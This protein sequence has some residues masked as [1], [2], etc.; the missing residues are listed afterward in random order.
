MKT[1][2]KILFAPFI[3]LVHACSP[4]GSHVEKDVS[5]SFYFNKSK[6]DV[7]YSPMGNWFE[8]EASKMEVDVASF[9]VLNRH[10][11]K[12]K[13]RAYYQSTYIVN[14]DLDL[15]SFHTKQDQYMYNI[16]MDHQ[17]VYLFERNYSSKETVYQIITDA[18]PQTF[19]IIDYD[20]AKDNQH[21]YH[22]YKPVQVDY[23]SF[24]RINNRFHM[25][26]NQA[27]YHTHELFESFD[28]D[29]ESF[30]KIDDVYAYDKNYVYHFVEY[31]KD[32]AENELKLIPNP[33]SRK[34]RILNSTH[35]T[36]GEKIYYQGFEIE[37]VDINTFKVIHEYHSKDRYKVYFEGI[38]IVGADAESFHYDDKIYRYKDK[39]HTYN[40][41]KPVD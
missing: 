8:L 41:G 19:T 10:I 21:Y 31:V 38:E 7:I 37:G 32:R 18:D 6:T 14:P 29:V 20:W 27:Y 25:D 39:N 13:N 16:G 36:T 15:T 2:L 40:Q 5:D 4:L 23:E 3:W 26:K 24:E 1:F 9:K 22:R 12:D 33:D 11:A 28:V 34:V 35:F 17:N 30:K